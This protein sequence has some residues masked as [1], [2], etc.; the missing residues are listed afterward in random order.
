MQLRPILSTLSR[1]KAAATLIVLEIALTCAIICNAL[2]LIGQRIDGMQRSSGMDESRLL[3]VYVGSRRKAADAV[4][5][6]DGNTSADLQ[7]L[8]TIPGVESVSTTNQLPFFT[9]N[10]VSNPIALTRNQQIPNLSAASYFVGDDFVRTLGLRIITGRDFRDDEYIDGRAL[11]RMNDAE[12]AKVRGATIITQSVARKLFGQQSALGKNLYIGPITMTVVGVVEML[13]RPALGEGSPGGPPN[14]D[15]SIILPV[16]RSADSGVSYVLRVQ[17]PARRTEVMAQIP[18]ALKQ[19]APN[20]LLLSNQPYDSIRASFFRNDRAMMG[21]LVA[22]CVALLA[23]TAFGIVG[24]SSF[25]VQQRTKQIGIRRALGATRSQIM[26]YFQTENFILASIGIG[27]GM[28]AAYGINQLLMHYYELPRLP[29]LYLPAGAVV[30]WLLG[31]LA[32]L[33]PA[34]KAASIPPALATRSA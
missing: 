14:L 9:D 17:D 13:A 29:L 2:F 27:L 1:H 8:R 21:L 4:G 18:G 11:F 10:D 19:V 5:D 28:F 16:R 7:A 25:W 3:Q 33:G 26:Q 34:R 24:L 12:L 6:P 15:D 32:V 31:Q 30:L 20:R 23:I 22:I